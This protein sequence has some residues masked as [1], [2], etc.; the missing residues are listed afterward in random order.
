[1]LSVKNLDMGPLGD[2]REKKFGH[3]SFRGIS[4]RERVKWRWIERGRDALV[5]CR[6]ARRR[7]ANVMSNK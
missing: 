6:S 2:F 5:S 4:E 7:F 3:G 1:M